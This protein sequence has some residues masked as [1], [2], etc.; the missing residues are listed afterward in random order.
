MPTNEVGLHIEYHPSMSEDI[1]QG[2]NKFAGSD[3]FA[4][5]VQKR[6]QESAEE[7]LPTPKPTE[8]SVEPKAAWNLDFLD[9]KIAS[10]PITS[11]PPPNSMTSNMSVNNT[12]PK[13]KSNLIEAKPISPPKSKPK[14]K[15]SPEELEKKLLGLDLI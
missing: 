1:F 14:P 12:M 11:P 6:K 7:I 15:L 4:G 8:K 3:I 13:I 9:I 5:M 10:G 2:N